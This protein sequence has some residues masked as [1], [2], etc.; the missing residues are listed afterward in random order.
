M[1]YAE[2]LQAWRAGA[3]PVHNLAGRK[4]EALQAPNGGNLPV[5]PVLPVTQHEGEQ[6]PEP[7]ELSPARMDNPLS[8]PVLVL[9]RCGH[10]RHF[11]RDKVSPAEGIGRCGAGVESERPNY[12]N[13]PRHCETWNPTSAALS[14][15][16]QQVEDL[17]THRAV[18]LK[19]TVYSSKKNGSIMLERCT[20]P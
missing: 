2:L 10:C 6:N 8:A 7:A 17:E 12:P 14:H 5:I 19:A 4:R 11:E 18:D 16:Y 1:S 3:L 13:A 20:A 15:R 9:V